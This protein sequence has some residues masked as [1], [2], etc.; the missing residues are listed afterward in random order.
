MNIAGIV[1]QSLDLNTVWLTMDS[2]WIIQRL[3][4]CKTQTQNISEYI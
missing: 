3:V 4:L 2:H 1:I